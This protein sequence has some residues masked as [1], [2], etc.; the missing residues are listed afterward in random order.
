MVIDKAQQICDDPL[1]TL[2]GKKTRDHYRDEQIIH[3][4]LSVPGYLDRL[5]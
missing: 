3:L 1:T 2:Q 5:Q 4:H